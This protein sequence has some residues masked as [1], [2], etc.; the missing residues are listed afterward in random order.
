MGKILFALAFHRNAR[1][2]GCGAGRP[3]Y[4]SFDRA[5]K[6]S[7]RLR[8]TERQANVEQFLVE[9]AILPAGDLLVLCR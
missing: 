8:P 5:V 3:G 7:G 1:L 4:P 6:H 2:V 9:A